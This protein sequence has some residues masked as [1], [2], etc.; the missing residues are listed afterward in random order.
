M[1]VSVIVVSLL[2]PDSLF[3]SLQVGG[4]GLVGMEIERFVFGVGRSVLQDV[5]VAVA[6]A[7]ARGSGTVFVSADEAVGSMPFAG[8]LTPLCIWRAQ[9]F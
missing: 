9:Y 5:A 4:G 8:L 6:V 3:S 2:L 1:V 7:V